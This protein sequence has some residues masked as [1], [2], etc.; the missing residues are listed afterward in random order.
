VIS[1]EVY[2]Q[3]FY[4]DDIQGVRAI[5]AF[6][7]MVHH[8]W[9]HKVS[10][11]VDVF[12]VVSGFLMGSILLR[13]Y[14]EKGIVNPFAFYAKVSKRVFPSAFL[15][16]ALTGLFTLVMVPVPLWKFGINEFVA[17]AIQLENWELWRQSVD[18]LARE[19]PQSQFQQYWALSMQMQFYFVLPLVFFIA[20]T[21]LKRINAVYS[22]AF[23]CLA[24]FLASLIYSITKTSV[25]PAQSYFNTLM[26][27]WE[28]FFGVLIAVVYPYLDFSRV[29]KKFL[30]VVVMLSLGV[31]V[32]F[33]FWVPDSLNFPGWVALVPVTAIALVI[34]FGKSAGRGGASFI[35]NRYVSGMG[36]Y[37]FTLYLC[38]WPILVFCQHYLGS[39]ELTVFQG[40][41]VI[42]LSI[43]SSM[44]I[45]YFF[46]RPLQNGMKSVKVIPSLAVSMALIAIFSSGGLYARQHLIDVAD[47]RKYAEAP[48]GA[49]F[50]GASFGSVDFTYWL[51]VDFDRAHAIDNCLGK[52]CYYGN[53]DSDKSV[54]LFGASHAAHYQPLFESLAYR[55]D[56]KLITILSHRQGSKIV[57]EIDPD[58]VVSSG[59][60]TPHPGVSED[61][62]IPNGWAEMWASLDAKDIP[63]LLIRDTPRFNFYQNACLWKAVDSEI[64]CSI[65]RSSIYSE[66]N[67]L[68]DI[69]QHYERLYAVDFSSL[70]CDDNRCFAEK[71]ALPIYYDKHHFSNRFVLSNA[72]EMKLAIKE[73]APE[74]YNYLVK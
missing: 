72:K 74:F 1:S 30:T 73:Q 44:A 28:F 16:L 33:G 14:A 71:D 55:Y 24:L 34:I 60:V 49:V 43:L 42:L 62:T 31:F 21:F 9:T 52:V 7:I 2:K 8:I 26:R 35:A 46:E 4:R 11:G 67:P 45:Y 70:V 48:S 64:D 17:S 57:E 23:C 6:L 38:H 56:F 19:N 20:T 68:Q 22:L 18:Y 29:P 58:F 13:E 61:E 59:T 63:T 37:S 39:T 10:G 65:D 51:T 54:V 32:T 50:D 15:V 5:S 25:S 3:K 69:V 36:K 12:F 40:G 27:F 53:V 41:L 47:A 66:D